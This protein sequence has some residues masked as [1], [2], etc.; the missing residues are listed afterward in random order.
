[1]LRQNY[2]CRNK[3]FARVIIFCML[4]CLGAY[5][6]NQPADNIYINSD[7]LTFDKSK[8]TA[9]FNGNVVV[10]FEDLILTSSDLQIIYKKNSAGKNQIDRIIIPNKLK[11][12]RIKDHEVLI[13]QN[14]EYKMDSSKLTLRY[15][16][17]MKDDD[18]LQTP[19]LIYYGML[20]KIE[21]K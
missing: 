9:D 20:Q 11:A 10:W 15:V 14:G 19:E 4:C 1:M 3:P 7:L 12:I 16:E 18:I 13:A 6:S 21:S 2:M 17:L 8:N 5:A